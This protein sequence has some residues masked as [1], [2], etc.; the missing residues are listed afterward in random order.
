MLAAAG[1]AELHHAG[2]LLAEA[3][4]PRAVDAAR[5]VGGDPP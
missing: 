4:A 3:D 5:H 1:H 2:D